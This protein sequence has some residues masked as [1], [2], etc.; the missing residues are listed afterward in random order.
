M[1]PEPHVPRLEGLLEALPNPVFVKDE[2]HRWVLL[3]DAYCRFMGYERSQLIGRS[4]PDFFPK[5]EADVFWRQ[6][7][8]VLSS[9]RDDE[10][11]EHFTDAAGN[12]H[13][14]VTRKTLH[15]DPDGR[16]FL[17]G[18]ITDITERKQMEEALRRSRDNL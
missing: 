9:G 7:D 6:D 16:R 10:N 1:T 5:A 3:N 15:V 17:V 14:I 4:D 8:L 12:L 13:V 11:E 2:Q 18:V